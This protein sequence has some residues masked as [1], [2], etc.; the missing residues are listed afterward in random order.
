MRNKRKHIVIPSRLQDYVAALAEQPSPL[1]NSEHCTP[2]HKCFPP[3]YI[4]RLVTVSL[5]PRPTTLT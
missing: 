3:V 4:F 2:C 5:W 1:L